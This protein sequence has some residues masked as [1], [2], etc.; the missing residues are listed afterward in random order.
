MTKQNLNRV[1]GIG[2][3]V[4]FVYVLLASG[5]TAWLNPEALQT[6]VTNF[7]V[8]APMVFIGAY[9]VATLF[10]VPGS[11]LSLLGGVLFGPVYGTLYVV[12]GAT[13][14]ALLAFLFSRRLG[15]LLSKSS[16]GAIVEKLRV[17]D[18]R[19]AANGFVTILF[20]RLVPLF[21]FNG[22][23]FALGLTRVRFRDYALGT[24]LGIMPG[25]FAYVYFG[26]SLASLSIVQIG[27]AILLIGAV[28]I[29]GR[30]IAHRYSPTH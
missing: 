24:F 9:I 21:P 17:Y 28:I 6:T 27:T 18:E 23:N 29:L 22:L 4:V 11:P 10:F 15:T 20:L 3:I 12:I 5:F 19:I 26:D 30:L 8:F 14:G 7:G 2:L 25:T 1:A 13:L 16:D